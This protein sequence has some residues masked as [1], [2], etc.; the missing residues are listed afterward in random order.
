MGT[1][2]LTALYVYPVKSM[3]GISCD[4]AVLTGTGLHRDRR[5]M[6]VGTDGRFV[7]QRNEPRLALVVTRLEPDAVVLSRDGHGSIALPFSP[8]G[9]TA[10]AT[11]VWKDPIEAVDEGDAAA[12]WLTTALGSR[13]PVRIVRMAPGFRRQLKDP[14]RF[15]PDTT[16]GFADAAPYL[17]A[18]E[19]SLDALNRELH[20]RGHA[21]VP[22]DRF[23]PNIVVR[24]LGPFAEHRMAALEGDGWRLK[25]VDPC[26]RCVVTTIDQTTAERDPAREPYLT[27]R[28]ANRAPGSDPAPAFGQNAILTAGEGA[29]VRVGARMSVR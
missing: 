19:G 29:A 21:P 18:N 14:D 24:G 13:Q 8:D 11:Q 4:E 28:R 10:V 17:V 26:E 1:A 2:L 20:S 22:M 12:N 25:L 27:L 3:R 9:G 16:T 6:V 5:W 23:R 7:T 15:G